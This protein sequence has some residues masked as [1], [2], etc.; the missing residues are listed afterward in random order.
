MAQWV[1]FE[2]Y[3]GFEILDDASMIRIE[4]VEH[5]L[6]AGKAFYFTNPN[7]GVKNFAKPDVLLKRAQKV[8]T[9]KLPKEKKVKVAKVSLTPETDIEQKVA[10]IAKERKENPIKISLTGRD[11]LAK[12]VETG[13]MIFYNTKSYGWQES[14]HAP[15]DILAQIDADVSAGKTPK[16]P[17]QN[18]G[19][20]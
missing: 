3:A 17:V 13:S 11:A 20:N 5:E 19:I 9:V 1:K 16:W 15:S 6:S 12:A 4:G 10:M 18:W 8:K 7:T 2:Q 14:K